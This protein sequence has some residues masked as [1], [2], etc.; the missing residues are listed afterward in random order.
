[1]AEIEYAEEIKEELSN[2]L[3]KTSP[4]GVTASRYGLTAPQEKFTE[5]LSHKYYDTVTLQISNM[6]RFHAGHI[7]VQKVFNQMDNEKVV[8]LVHHML[9]HQTHHVGLRQLHHM[10]SNVYWKDRL[11]SVKKLCPAWDVITIPD[12]I[13]LIQFTQLCLRRINILQ[14]NSP[15][16]ELEMQ[17]GILVTDAPR[18]SGTVNSHSLGSTVV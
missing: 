13:G 3:K 15:V 14:R 4:Y 5:R 7:L 9:I 11:T 1:M 8:A 16:V 12:T 2:V 10:F 18:R 17:C 6:A